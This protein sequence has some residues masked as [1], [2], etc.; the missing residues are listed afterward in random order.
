MT[1]YTPSKKI[2]AYLQM[3]E[4]FRTKEGIKKGEVAGT[5]SMRDIRGMKRLLNNYG[6]IKEHERQ[7]LFDALIS[8]IDRDYHQNGNLNWHH[9]L[10]PFGIDDKQRSQGLEWLC[11]NLRRWEREAKGKF[12]LD[13]R[14]CAFVNGVR[15]AIT[16]GQFKEFRFGGFQKTAPDNHIT[17]KY[18]VFNVIPIW[19]I[20]LNDGTSF[21]Y[22]YGSWQSNSGLEYSPDFNIKE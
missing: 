3:I 21:A 10:S 1:T 12:R 8:A 19:Q 15:D 14:F 20:I 2:K 22:S 7:E 13:S 11:K 17:S 4:Q 6:K 18:G 9:T 16:H 5:F